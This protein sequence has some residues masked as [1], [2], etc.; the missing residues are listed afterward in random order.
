MI[1]FKTNKF[2]EK[3][4]WEIVR[5]CNKVFFSVTDGYFN[6]Y[7]YFIDTYSPDSVIFYSDRRYIHSN[8]YKKLGFKFSYTDSPNCWYFKLPDMQLY[9]SAKFKNIELENLI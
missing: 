3:H 7:K 8:L 5:F 6:I 9:S 1:V 2:N 4:E